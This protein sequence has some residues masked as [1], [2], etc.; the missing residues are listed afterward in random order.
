VSTR[1]RRRLS[2]IFGVSG[3]LNAAHV[4]CDAGRLRHVLAGHALSDRSTPD[5]AHL[6]R[7]ALRLGYALHTSCSTVRSAARCYCRSSSPFAS[8]SSCSTWR[9]GCG[10]P[11]TGCS[12]RRT[13]SAASCGPLI[14]P[15]LAW[16]RRVL[17]RGDGGGALVAAGL[18]PPRRMIRRPRRTS[19][20][21]ADGRRQPA[22]RILR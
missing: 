1:R 22:R 7:A 19:E 13:S 11:T 20:N 5:A 16:S 17:G 4:S 14:V 2:L 10:A 15:S 18:D 9:S 12:G 21:G 8:R 6:V 3:I